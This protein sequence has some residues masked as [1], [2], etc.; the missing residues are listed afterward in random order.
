MNRSTYGNF[1]AAFK[2]VRGI[3]IAPNRGFR[4]SSRLGSAPEPHLSKEHDLKEVSD[5]EW[6]LRAGRAISVIRETMPDFFKLGLVERTTEDD[7]SESIYSPRIQL[8]YTPPTRLPPF[9]PTLQIEG[10]PMYHAS[11]MFVRHTLNMFYTNLSVELRRLQETKVGHRDRRFTLGIGVLGTSRMGGSAAEWDVSSTY[12]I[13][14][15][16][17]LVYRHVVESIHPAPHSSIYSS[18]A[19]TLARLS[20]FK[21][22]PEPAVPGAIPAVKDSRQ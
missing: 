2:R 7:G 14:P 22:S 8:L 16:S 12:Y 15:V 13:S 19:S 18:L 5:T 1:R 21:T 9:P 11:S 20:G 6:E 4:P 17:G 3:H 10:L